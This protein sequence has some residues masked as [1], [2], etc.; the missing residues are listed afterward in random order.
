MKD[1]EIEFLS[2]S[3][4]IEREYSGEALEDAKQAWTMAKL[5]LDEPISVN[6]ILA[7][8]R[9]LMK[10]LNLK[11][12]GKI[13]KVRVGVMTKDGFKEAINFKEIKEEL[14]LLCNPGLY[15]ISSENLIK[16]WHIRF[17]EIHPFEDGNGRTCRILMNI[18]RLKIGLPLLIIYNKDK[19]KY[20]EWFKDIE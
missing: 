12:A 19:S 8:H 9:R 17:E 10:R 6:Y 4:K 13:R 3:N 5:Y 20:Y 11:I 7:I 15:P 14:R 1:E 18:Q 16:R 2:E